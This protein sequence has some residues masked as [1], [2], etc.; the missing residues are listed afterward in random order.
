M[1][2]NEY[3][4]KFIGNAWVSLKN[5]QAKLYMSNH[6]PEQRKESSMECNF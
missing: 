4:C 2:I 6:F 5:S 1:A 3:V